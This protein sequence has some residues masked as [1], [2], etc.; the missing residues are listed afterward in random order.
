MYRPR[1]TKTTHRKYS[2]LKGMQTH[3]CWRSPWKAHPR[4]HWDVTHSDK[5]GTKSL[6]RSR[7]NWRIHHL[8]VILS[9]L[10]FSIFCQ[11]VGCLLYPFFHCSQPPSWPIN[12]I[13]NISNY[14]K[15]TLTKSVLNPFSSIFWKW[16]LYYHLTWRGH[17]F[18]FGVMH[19][20]Q[21]WQ[22]KPLWFVWPFSWHK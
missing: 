20:F 2:R 1:Q 15:S 7:A 18:H 10:C 11:I 12:D 6:G 22:I 8:G 3:S 13:K 21:T 16:P 5:R 19:S 4:Q 14:K 9:S 17:N